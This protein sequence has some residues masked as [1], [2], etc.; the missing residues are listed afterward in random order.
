MGEIGAPLMP[1][2]ESADMHQRL[3]LANK[4]FEMMHN[5]CFQERTRAAIQDLYAVHLRQLALHLPPRF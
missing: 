2:R 4:L 3:Q 5:P 1:V